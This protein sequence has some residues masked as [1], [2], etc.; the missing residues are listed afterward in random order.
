MKNFTSWADK[1][2]PG[3]LSIPIKPPKNF[4]PENDKNDRGRNKSRKIRKNS[5]LLVNFH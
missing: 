1:S 5:E 4:S 3:Y 2:Q